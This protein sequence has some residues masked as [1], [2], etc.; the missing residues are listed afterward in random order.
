M[1]GSPWST[2]D[3]G[4]RHRLMLTA[5]RRLFPQDPSDR[6]QFLIVFAWLQLVGGGLGVVALVTALGRGWIGWPGLILGLL[7][8]P[9][10]LYL[11]T[12]LVWGLIGV[13]AGG[14]A[15]T[16]LASGDVPQAVSFSVEEALL[17][18]GRVDEAVASFEARLRANPTSVAVRLALAAVHRDAR[19]DYPAAERL[20][21]ELR[22]MVGSPDDAVGNAL[23]DLYERMG[24]RGRLMAELARFAARHPGTPAGE[25]ARRR[26]SELK[27]PS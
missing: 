10:G 17:V 13:A 9:A 19:K 2:D 3:P 21:L 5:L 16:V 12:W 22:R 15:R 23:I 4:A 26:L 27:E 24:E 11:L 7:A 20:Y 8:L 1:E 6:H 25:G 18:R 14:F